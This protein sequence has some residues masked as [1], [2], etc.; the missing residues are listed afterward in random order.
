VRDEE[1]SVGKKKLVR[2]AEPPSKRGIAWPRWTGFRGMTVRNWLELLV[3]PLALVVIGFLFSVQQDARQQRIEDQ[4]AEAERELAE[5][6][7]Q[8][9]AL[10]AYLDQMGSLLLERK[11]RNST[12]GGEVRTL[13]RARTLSV[14]ERLDENRKARALRFLYEANLITSPHPIISLET[15]DLR[16]ADLSAATTTIAVRPGVDMLAPTPPTNWSRIDL[17]GSY[18][19]NANLLGDNLRNADLSRTHLYG[20]NL[21][22]AD[23]S[24]ANLSG[25]VLGPTIFALPEEN[26]SRAD[27]RDIRADL[28]KTDL[29]GAN[30]EGALVSGE[31]LEQQPKTLQGATMPD[32]QTLKSTANPDR[33][34]FE[35]WLKDRER[36]GEDGENS[37][38]S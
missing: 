16:G 5:Q 3:V 7:A 29:S 21:S 31:Q 14:L 23:L 19:S 36:R 24:D 8:D 28:S 37:S 15:A 34:T 4:R 26:L 32:G 1:S 27:V 13:A 11:L 38:P 30:L 35:D 10:Q 22:E 6:R 33:P 2:K 17:S 12:E 20:S 18:L 25:A 9:E